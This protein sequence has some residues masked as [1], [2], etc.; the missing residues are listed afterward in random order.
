MSRT[1]EDVKSD[2]KNKTFAPVYLIYGEEMY[3]RENCRKMLL[4][5]LVAPGDT[6]NYA[7]FSGKSTDPE[8]VVS[9]AMTLPFMAEK[10]VV[11][12]T[13]SGFFKKAAEPVTDYIKDPAEDTV[14]IFVESSIDKK[15]A[16]YTAAKKKGYDVEAAKYE[17][18]KLPRWIAA[19]FKR[20]DKKIS[21]ETVN[22]LLERAG[23]DMSA[24]DREINKLA[25]YAGERDV[26][27]NEDVMA[28]VTRSPDFRVF[29]MMDAIVDKK[30]NKAVGMYYDM[31]SGKE[32]PFGVL[33]LLERHFRILL[34]VSDMSERKADTGE[35]AK[36][37]GIGPGFVY[38]YANQGRK[39]SRAGMIKA[40]DSCAAAERDVKQGK[41]GEEAAIELLII[42]IASGQ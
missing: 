10:R 14:L 29:Q 40:L 15:C 31:L 26:I 42:S 32:S 22:L 41:L 3:L 18:S 36:A 28:L 38:K 19:N 4:N 30:L 21:S 7:R 37:A 25:S 35:I 8:E 23:N 9:I 27:T 17:Q 34:T 2:V 39:Y 33:A 6:L 24:L 5:A 13:D 16:S 12:V 1:F 11:L 20:Y